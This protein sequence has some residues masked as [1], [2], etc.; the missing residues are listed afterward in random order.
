MQTQLKFEDGTLQNFW[1]AL[2]D[3]ETAAHVHK[4]DNSK[5]FAEVGQY[6]KEQGQLKRF[7]IDLLHSHFTVSADEIL[8]T[9][10][11]QNA[12]YLLASLL[13]NR[14]TTFGIENPGYTDARNIAS[15]QA[16]VGAQPPPIALRMDWQAVRKS[17]TR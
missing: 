5:F 17:L 4:E 10:G 15:L 6:L 16:R 8:V 2:P 14:D 3:L 12:L 11:A 1:G 13:F 7:G 9:V